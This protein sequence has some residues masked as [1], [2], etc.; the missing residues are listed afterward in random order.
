MKKRIK[1]AIAL[2]LCVVVLASIFTVPA[3]AANSSQALPT[4]PEFVNTIISW[5][6]RPLFWLAN[7]FIRLLFPGL[8]G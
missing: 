1:T 3:F 6:F 8:G 7:L 4:L 2:L 5:R